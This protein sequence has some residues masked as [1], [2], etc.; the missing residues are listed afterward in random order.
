MNDPSLLSAKDGK[1]LSFVAAV[2]VVNKASAYLKALEQRK[3]DTSRHL[4]DLRSACDDYREC[5][6]MNARYKK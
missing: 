3:I 4:Q 1:P 2:K 5:I 6:E